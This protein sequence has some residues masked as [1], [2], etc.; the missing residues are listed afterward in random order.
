[1]AL[2]KRLEHK[3]INTEKW[4]ALLLPPTVSLNTLLLWAWSFSVTSGDSSAPPNPQ[5]TFWMVQGHF[6]RYWYWMTSRTTFSYTTQKLVP[7]HCRA[8]DGKVVEKNI[9]ECPQIIYTNYILHTHCLPFP[10]CLYHRES[11]RSPTLSSKLS[12]Y[13]HWFGFIPRASCVSCIM[14]VMYVSLSFSHTPNQIQQQ[15]GT[16]VCL[17]VWCNV[18]CTRT[19]SETILGTFAQVSGTST[20]FMGK[21]GVSW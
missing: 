7:K 15:W 1:M 2:I 19:S 5:V 20:Q 14:C 21:W 16:L 12:R 11:W 3:L 4:L 17:P 18:G 10:F 9:K 6:S 13:G 8:G